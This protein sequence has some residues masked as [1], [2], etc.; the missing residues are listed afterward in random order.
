[1]R[2]NEEYMSASFVFGGI[3]IYRKSRL[4]VGLGEGGS[5]SS[6]GRGGDGGGLSMAGERG[7]GRGGGNG[8][9]AYS[10]GTLPSGGG[11]F[12]S[13]FSWQSTK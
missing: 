6:S 9:A 2:Q 4:I 8:G 5:A 7:G 12:G 3:F 10:P 11:I 13:L 1:M